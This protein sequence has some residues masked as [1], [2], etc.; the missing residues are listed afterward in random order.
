MD[1]DQKMNTLAHS[2]LP[3]GSGF[4]EGKQDTACGV[5]DLLSLHF[6]ISVGMHDWFGKC[7]LF[8]RSAPA[9]I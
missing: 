2:S 5:E 3:K 4:G 9:V 8:G 6:L 7:R 1:E